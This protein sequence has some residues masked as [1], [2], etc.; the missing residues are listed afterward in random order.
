MSP[1]RVMCCSAGLASTGLELGRDI[2]GLSSSRT[3]KS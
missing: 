1:L 2:E 3:A